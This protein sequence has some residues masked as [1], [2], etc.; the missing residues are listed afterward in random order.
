MVSAIDKKTG[1]HVAIKKM[2]DPWRTAIHGRRTYREL[3]L[4]RYVR[5]AWPT[6]S[7]RAPEPD[8]EPPTYQHQ[9]IVALL[10]CFVTSTGPG[11]ESLYLVMEHGGIDLSKVYKDVEV[12]GCTGI[13]GG[14]DACR[15][16]DLYYYRLHGCVT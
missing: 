6:A 13:V 2:F 7:P 16:C 8:D 3:R 15:V 12:G 11:E 10:N 4:L 14:L 5:D 1:L 9:Q